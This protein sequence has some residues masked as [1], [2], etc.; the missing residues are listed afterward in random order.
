M[1]NKPGIRPALIFIG[2]ATSSDDV[3]S[4]TWTSWTSTSATGTGT[5][6]I[7]TCRP[8]CG[9]GGTYT[10]FPVTVRLSSPGYL[11]GMPL[12]KT[13]SMTPTTSAGKPETVTAVRPYGAWGWVP[14]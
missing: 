7:N 12:F 9:V 5:H 3:R 13:I 14:N 4:I 8:T 1:A 2:C 11:D 6:A 10:Y